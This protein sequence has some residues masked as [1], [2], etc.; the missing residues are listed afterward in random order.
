V[1]TVAFSGATVCKGA[2]NG[3]FVQTRYRIRRK[4]LLYF[5]SFA[6]QTG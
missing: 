6:M 2:A 5:L 1:Q 3:K 4:K